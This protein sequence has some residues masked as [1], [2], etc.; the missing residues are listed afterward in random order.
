MPAQYYNQG[1]AEVTYLNTKVA[2]PMAG[3]FASTYANNATLN[4]ATIQQYLLLVPF[5]E[6]G[7]VT[8]QN[9]SIG[10]TPYNSLQIQVS[11]P[12]SHHLS[13]Q[14][15]FTWDKLM[16]HNAYLNNSGI[17]THLESVQDS[18]SNVLANVFG[19]YELPAFAKSPYWSGWRSAAGS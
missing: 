15:N 6:F 1:A 18:N 12:M 3:Q 7:T 19:T 9:S 5:P 4:A 16:L 10:S 17:D 11:H 13:I 14:G 8:E 2:N